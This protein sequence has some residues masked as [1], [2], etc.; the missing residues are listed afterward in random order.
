MLIKRPQ[1]R[2]F[3][4]VHDHRPS[5][6]KGYSPVTAARSRASK[7]KRATSASRRAAAVQRALRQFRVIFSSVRSH[8]AWLER[9]CGIGGA[10]VWALAV[11]ARRPGIRVGELAAALSIHQSTAS[12]LLDRLLRS[13]FVRRHRDARDRRVARLEVTA[14]GRGV[15]RRAPQPIEGV[16]P[17]ALDR[18]PAAAL[19][20]LG[21]D[22]DAV[23][24]TM[25]V[26][27]ERAAYTPLADL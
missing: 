3:L 10:Q 5:S 1:G 21:R 24:R 23:I 7:P 13:R 27:D 14:R 6:R 11:V 4:A 18:I 12:N 15:L 9:A 16:L 8:F 20:R 25:R 2:F 19:A 22:L 26:K 17:D